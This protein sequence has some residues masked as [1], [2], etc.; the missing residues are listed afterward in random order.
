MKKHLL[1]LSIILLS[2]MTYSQP[3]K[4]LKKDKNN[5]NSEIRVVSDSLA[6]FTIVEEMPSFPG[7]DK[8]RNRFLA[9]NLVYPE[10]ATKYGIQGTVYIQFVIDAD[11]FVTNVK[12]LQGIGGGCDEE[13]VR[14]V[15]LMPKWI[16][17][18]QKGKPVSVLFNMPIYFKLEGK[19]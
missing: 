9:T 19:R 4:T 7:G 13:A 10:L 8:R 17:G 12:V 11:G 3:S 1:V 18:K 16:P 14:V 5:K 2:F 15:K 6:I